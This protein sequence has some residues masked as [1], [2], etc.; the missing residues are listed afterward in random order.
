M[1]VLARA[2]WKIVH[3]PAPDWVKLGV[4]VGGLVGLAMFSVA[5][6]AMTLG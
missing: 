1:G 6:E 4:V 2:Y 5:S 3:H